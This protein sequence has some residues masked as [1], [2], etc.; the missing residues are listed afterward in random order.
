MRLGSSTRRR[1]TSESRRHERRPEE[2][3]ERGALPRGP[4][5]PPLRDH[6]SDSAAPG[7]ARRHP[8]LATLVRLYASEN[9]KPIRASSRGDEAL[10]E[11]RLGPPKRAGARERGSSGR[12]CSARPVDRPRPSSGN[13]PAA[14]P[15]RGHG[16]AARERVHYRDLIEEYGAVSAPRSRRTG[17]CR[18]RRAELLS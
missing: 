11:L 7:T 9:D 6:H 15:R 4:L 12:S 16:A 1:R 5:L 8:L 2:A 17:A 18:R 3:R 13:G 14:G 10:L